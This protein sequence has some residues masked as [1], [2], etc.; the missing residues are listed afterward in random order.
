MAAVGKSDKVQRFEP[1]PAKIS[2]TKSGLPHHLPS[3]PRETIGRLA[4]AQ[5]SIPVAQPGG[6]YQNASSGA[7]M[8]LPLPCPRQFLRIH[9]CLRAP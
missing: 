6:R 3:K 5:I 1:G 4:I 8:S 2:T 7:R 9:G